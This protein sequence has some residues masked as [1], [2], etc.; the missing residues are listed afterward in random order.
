MDNYQVA[1]TLRSLSDANRQMGL[2]EEGVQL[3]KEALEIYEQ[4]GDTVEQ[5]RCLIDLAWLLLADTQLNAAEEAASQAIN[6]L[7]EEGKQFEV[8]RSHRVLGSIHHS[9]GE[10]EEAIDHFEMAL[11][12]ASSFNWHHELFWIHYSLAQVFSRED[13]FD[14]T[15]VHIKHAKSYAGDGSYTLGCAMELCYVF[16]LRNLS[17]TAKSLAPDV[18]NHKNMISKL[19]PITYLILSHTPFLSYLITQDINQRQDHIRLSIRSKPEPDPWP[20]SL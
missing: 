11:S 20:L 15:L 3:V 17:S 12:V 18:E 5:A 7:P 4:L 9:K 19:F 2:Y 1:E 16:R 13:R 10:T 14:D 6:L 8:S